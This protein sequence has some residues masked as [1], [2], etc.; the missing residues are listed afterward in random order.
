[1]TPTEDFAKR[2]QQ[3]EALI[4]QQAPANLHEK[5]IA[6]LR[7]AIALTTTRAD[8]TQL[9]IGSSK[10]GG[11]PDVPN[12]FE[13]PMWN[14]EPLSFLVQINLEEIASYDDQELLPKHGLLSFFFSWSDWSGTAE[15]I[16]RI[17][18]FDS[19]K[20]VRSSS[21]ADRAIPSDPFAISVEGYYEIEVPFAPVGNWTQEEIDELGPLTELPYGPLAHDGELYRPECWNKMFG[22]GDDAYGAPHSSFC[23]QQDHYPWQSLLQ[24]YLPQ[25]PGGAPNFGEA[26]LLYFSIHL[27]DLRE[28]RFHKAD[29]GVGAS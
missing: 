11:S 3:A 2:R 15:N 17:R 1:M 29:F 4:R 21:A 7:P 19:S 25:F 12:G 26:V 10:F 27:D 6:L 22:Y 13:W 5:L 28:R 23:Y 20:L 14:E 18:W 16:C 9:P 8:D 24:L